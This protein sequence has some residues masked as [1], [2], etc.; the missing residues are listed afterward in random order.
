M[1]EISWG[2]IGCGEVTEQKSGPAFNKVTDS[3]LFGVMRRNENAL[4][5]YASRHNVPFFST[6]ADE[7][8]NHPEVN[9][10]YIA[11]P[12]S[13]HLHYIRKA[14]QAGKNV[15][16]EKPLCITVSEANEIKNLLISSGNKL[17]VAHYRREHPYFKT[18][19]HIIDEGRIGKPLW[20][21][22]NYYRKPFTPEDLKLNRN[23]WRVDPAISGGGLFFDLAP[24]QIDLML[25]L[26]GEP[27]EYAGKSFITQNI[28]PAPD[29]TTGFIKF[30]SGL[31]FQGNWN[32]NLEKA[33]QTDLV[34]IYG[35]EGVL[36]F[37]VFGKQVV[38]LTVGKEQ[39]ALRFATPQHV[40]QPLIEKVV[41]YFLNRNEN[42]SPVD[43]A[44]TI[45]AIMEIFSKII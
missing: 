17:S 43:N 21:I 41:G 22:L 31:I 38:E 1:Q 8:I 35:T 6:D 40:Q 19:K 28:Y 20:A 33:D 24:H 14:S 16:V 45:T 32:F 25:Y 29:T 23:K 30:R 44:L 15:Y 2:I 10:I 34:E 13:S 39:E 26:F 11:T 4:Q 18:I 27:M 3:K 36:K 5:D 37:P 7:L 9:A 12:P 42:P